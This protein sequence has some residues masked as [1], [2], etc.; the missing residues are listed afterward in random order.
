MRLLPDACSYLTEAQQLLSNIRGHLKGCLIY[1]R[2]KEQ[3]STEFS[4]QPSTSSALN[5]P[6]PK[7]EGELIP[8][9]EIRLP[10]GDGED[11]QTRKVASMQRLLDEFNRLHQK[12]ASAAAGCNDIGGE[13]KLSR[14]LDVFD[15]LNNLLNLVERFYFSFFW[16]YLLNFLPLF[17]SVNLCN[18]K[19]R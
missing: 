18:P 6:S 14:S 16:I 7:E 5:L 13:E 9:S 1:R 3:L 19:R 12:T 17:S 2:L 8:I 10:H 11:D 4:P 15:A